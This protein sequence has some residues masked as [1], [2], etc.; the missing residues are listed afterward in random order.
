MAGAAMTGHRRDPV[1]APFSLD[2]VLEHREAEPGTPGCGSLLM[3]PLL[4]H[5]RGQIAE[6]RAEGGRDLVSPTGD[7][8]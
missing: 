2:A 1:A 4:S 3:S 6:F 8:L 7:R 5:N